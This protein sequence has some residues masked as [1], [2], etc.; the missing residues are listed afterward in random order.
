[1][2]VLL[3]GCIGCGKF[4]FGSARVPDGRT[5]S[6]CRKKFH[7][8]GFFSPFSHGNELVRELIHTFKYER[9]RVIGEFLGS[10]ISSYLQKSGALNVRSKSAIVPVP[11]Y[12]SRE[13]RRGFNQAL[14]IAQVIGRELNITVLPKALKRVKKTKPQVGLS[15]DARRENVKDVFA[16]GG[17]NAVRGLTVFLVDDVKTTGATLEEAAK[18]LKAAGARKIIAV[19]AA[20]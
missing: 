7:I 18:T 5:C 11:L 2:P 9:V 15:G 10:C 8:Y 6:S 16:L 3:P 17:G 13:R 20:R 19:T 1:M 14:I 4:S 12:P